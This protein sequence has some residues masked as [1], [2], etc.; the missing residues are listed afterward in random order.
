MAVRPPTFRPRGQRSQNEARVERDDRR[1]S[2]LQRGYDARWEKLA[3]FFK[4][5]N[6]LCIGCKSVGKL[7]KTEVADHVVPHKGDPVLMWNIANLQ[8][9]CRFHHDVVKQ[10]LE[11]M[12]DRG[13]IGRDELK[14]SSISAQQLTR[15]LSWD[16]QPT[17]RG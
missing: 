8:P 15:D 17:P 16:Y 5:A 2:A 10:R 3:A 12:F 6:P 9:A 11:K 1:G 4:G 14:L 13:E 7:Q